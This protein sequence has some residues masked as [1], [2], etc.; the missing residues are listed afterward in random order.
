MP[1]SRSNK[2][3]R[4]RG[5]PMEVQLNY[6]GKHTDNKNFELFSQLDFTEEGNKEYNDYMDA[7]EKDLKE[8]ELM[9]HLLEKE[10]TPVKIDYSKMVPEHAENYGAQEMEDFWTEHNW[11]HECDI[12]WE[13]TRNGDCKCLGAVQKVDTFELHTYVSKNMTTGEDKYT[14]VPHVVRQVPILFYV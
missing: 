4:N 12:C 8:M 1:R 13:N 2:A 9:I 14:L 11:F 10:Q 6:Q 3:R 5:K 7:Q